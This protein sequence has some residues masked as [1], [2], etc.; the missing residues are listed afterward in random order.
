MQFSLAHLAEHCNAQ[1]EGDAHLLIHGV[2]NLQS[3]SEDMLSLYSDRKY[4]R[5]AQSSHAAALLTSKSLSAD[6]SGNKLIVDNP[7]LALARILS[8]FQPTQNTESSAGIDASAVVD[9][10]AVLGAG[11]RIAANVSIAADAV[12]GDGVYI[13]PGSQILPGVKI[14]EFTRIDANVTVYQ[15]CELGKRCHISAGAVIG[16][17]GFGFA[18]DGENGDIKWHAIPQTGIVRIGDDVHVGANTTIDRG[19]L[20]DTTIADGVIIDNLV[21][22]AHNVKI[23][24]HTAIAGCAAIAGSAV[25]GE[26]CKLGG[27]ASIIGHLSI[28]DN[29][30]IFADTLVTKSIQQAGVYSAAMPAMPINRWRK[31]LAKFRRI[32]AAK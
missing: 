11:V 29:V 32:Q 20:D 25:I 3:A 6:I 14:G 26:N 30:V 15:A 9:P 1:L 22:I 19:S 8:L 12:L 17:D 13:G 7:L 28:C 2:A 5:A 31:Q 24:R 18:E 23:G 10:R 16:A 4:R 21:Q 27:R